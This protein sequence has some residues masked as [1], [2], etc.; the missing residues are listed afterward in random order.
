MDVSKHNI[1]FMI[2]FGYR[3]IKFLLTFVDDCIPN[4]FSYVH[5]GNQQ[6][7]IHQKENKIIEVKG[8]EDLLITE[9]FEAIIGNKYYKGKIMTYPRVYTLIYKK[10]KEYLL[11]I[12]HKI[13]ENFTEKINQIQKKSIDDGENKIISQ[14]AIQQ[15]TT[16]KK[17]T[18]CQFYKFDFTIFLKRYNL[19]VIQIKTSEKSYNCILIDKKII[20]ETKN[21]YYLIGEN[22]T[23]GSLNQV[24]FKL[25][26]EIIDFGEKI[27]VSIIIANTKYLC[28]IKLIKENKKK[29]PKYYGIN[30]SEIINFLSQLLYPGF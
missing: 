14:D 26:D 5:L 17:S 1:T 7:E 15:F 20:L 11:D 2:P 21:D 8:S 18:T 24:N 13:K 22:K 27:F 30:G 9:E 6:Y 19:E 12:Y 29:E 3:T 28:K 10:G 23:G 25:S 16:P 4:S